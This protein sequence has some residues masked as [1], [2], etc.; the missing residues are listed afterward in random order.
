MMSLAPL[1][2]SL[3]AVL[4]VLVVVA[5]FARHADAQVPV[6][7]ASRTDER[8]R[9]DG[10]LDEP[11][12]QNASPIGPLLQAQPDEEVAATEETTVRVLYDASALYFG[13][14]CLD[15]N[16]SG[17]VS[18]Q[19]ARD[20]DLEVDDHVVVVLG[21]F[22]DHRN[23]FFFAVNPGGARIDGQISNNAE[24]PTLDWD[25][26]WNAGARIVPEG[27]VVEIVIPFKTLRFKPGQ[28]T[29]GLNIQR[30][31]KRRNEIDRWAGPRRNVW[32]TNLAEAGVL[33]D[34]PV[35][36]QGRGLELR[37]YGLVRRSDGQWEP[38]GG[39][40]ISKDLRPNLNGSL[41][42]NT[43]FAE[44]E[45]DTRQV[46]LTRFPLFY[47]EKRAFFLEGAG[48]F[49]TAG[50]SSFETDLL[51]FHS[52][53]I[54]LYEG[55][56]VPIIAGGKVAGR[57]SR[58]NIGFLDV[59]TARSDDLGLASQ[60]LLVAR[61][62]RDFWRQSYVGGIVTRGNPSGQGDNTLI[63]ADARLATSTF[64]GDDNLSVDLFLYRTSDEFT[65]R[66]DYAGGFKLDYPN[67]LWDARVSWKQIGSGFW[68]AL[69]FVPRTGIRKADFGVEFQPRPEKYGV[70]QFSFEV[71]STIV[72]D[73]DNVMESWLVETSPFGV[74]FES[75]D[76]IH[77]NVSPQFER[78][79][80]PFEIFP[81]F[82]IPAGSYTWAH[83]SAM[84][85]TAS[86]R[87]WV[88]QFNSGWGG[89]Y[90]GTRRDL[91]LGLVLKPSDHL[92]LAFRGERNDVSLDQGDF[93]VQLFSTEVGINL[94]PNLM[95]ASLLQYDNESRILGCQGRFRW[96][97]KPG[98]DL[99]FVI[100]SAW[101][102]EPDHSYLS[103][104]DS[105]AV[106]LQYTFR[107]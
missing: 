5:A 71:T 33:E 55:Q 28:T 92:R 88:I 47:P 61:V 10:R 17:I 57:Q 52:R 23:G 97:L 3:K 20:G 18:T 54:G 68:P 62:S 59:Q 37:P 40:D 30:Q 13:I 14:A 76:R 65:R 93:F 82:V 91:G 63:G 44:T 21:P 99:Y 72:T 64:R 56:E 75:G 87:P 24:H 81:G 22:F 106:K 4:C 69:G 19:L 51:P 39:L 16:P 96:I 42:L 15:R 25:G 12:W 77:F 45:V 78:L 60:N 7:K 38:D 36:S 86:K 49:E 102:R 31:I 79:Q 53:R 43:D 58:Y 46:N 50:T 83:Y 27:W 9:I 1:A 84:V 2:C 26:I 29:W 70:R 94:S 101:L 34:L 11:A 80:E 89:F 98:N 107:F 32:M 90:A 73:L 8:I 6:A 41:T 85:E 74:E 35:I 103:T 95:W 104:F 48:V 105:A 66:T 67:D 100:N